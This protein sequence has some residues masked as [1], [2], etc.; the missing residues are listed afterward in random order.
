MRQITLRDVPQELDHRLRELAQSQNKSLNRT[1]IGVLMESL[2]LGDGGDRK[3]D[4]SDLAGTWS[5]EEAEEFDS[6]TRMFERLDDD[7]RLLGVQASG[8]PSPVSTEGQFATAILASVRRRLLR[9]TIR[10]GCRRGG[11]ATVRRTYAGPIRCRGRYQ[12]ATC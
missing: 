7:Q 4:L 12:P 10:V 8:H 2:H 1:I 5:G 3:R 11:A 6:N 9:G